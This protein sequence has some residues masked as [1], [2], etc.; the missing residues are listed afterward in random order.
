MPHDI[1]LFC[2]AMF[3]PL[4]TSVT[5]W[6]YSIA[7]EFPFE[8]VPLFPDKLYYTLLLNNRDD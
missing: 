3:N 7:A 5:M 4:K 1:E 8:K 2:L 6:F